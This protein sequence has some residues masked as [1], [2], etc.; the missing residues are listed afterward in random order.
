MA[1]YT[2]YTAHPANCLNMPVLTQAN[3]SWEWCWKLAIQINSCRCTDNLET[4]QDCSLGFLGNC[5]QSFN[6][7]GF[8]FVC[9]PLSVHKPH[10][11]FAKAHRVVVKHLK[12]KLKVCQNEKVL[13]I[14]RST[15]SQ[16]WKCLK[17]RRPENWPA[18]LRVR[19]NS[20][21][22]TWSDRQDLAETSFLRNYLW[23]C[24]GARKVI[25]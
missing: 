19:F 10:V 23:F 18:D 6:S 5:S 20:S 14:C 8:C 15:I 4:H 24:N 21:Y 22:D 9:Y 2:T 7:N 25:R 3:E 16:D 17:L 13:L 11:S 12:T 1:P